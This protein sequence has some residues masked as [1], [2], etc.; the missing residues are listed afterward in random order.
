MRHHRGLYWASIL[1]RP[2]SLW[3][4]YPHQLWKQMC[5]DYIKSSGPWDNH[6]PGHLPAMQPDQRDQTSQQADQEEGDESC[7]KLERKRWKRGA[8]G[9]CVRRKSRDLTGL[10]SEPSLACFL[11]D[12]PVRHLANETHHTT[13]M[14]TL[15]NCDYFSILKPLTSLSPHSSH[16]CKLHTF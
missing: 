11:L 6:R 1:K 13:H 9:L 8:V 12:R 10:R 5:G 7:A 14:S 3:E 16:M 4:K 15:W 2:D